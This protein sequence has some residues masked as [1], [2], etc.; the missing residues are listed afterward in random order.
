MIRIKKV[1]FIWPQSSLFLL[2]SIFAF[3]LAVQV[4]IA[5]TLLFYSDSQTH[6]MSHEIIVAILIGYMAFLFKQQYQKHL[7]S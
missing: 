7:H 5:F 3:I 2:A 6:L 4:G 1:Q